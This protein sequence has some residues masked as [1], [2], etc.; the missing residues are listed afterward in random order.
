M[1]AADIERK[2]RSGERL[3]REDGIDLYGCD[4]LAWLGGLAHEVRSRHS[5]DIAYFAAHLPQ[6]VTDLD[7]A[8]ALTPRWAADGVTELRL[9]TGTGTGAGSEA[10]A[11]GLAG[12]VRALRDALPEGVALTAY[13]LPYGG[14]DAPVDP[15]QL[16]GRVLRLRELQDEVGGFHVAVPLL[17]DGPRGATGAEVLK[18]FAVARLL[19]DNVEHLA[20]DW[21]LHTE[22]TAQ[23]ALQHGADE[24]TGRVVDDESAAGQDADALTREDLLV[25]I[26]DAGF[27]PVERDAHYGAVRSHEGPDPQRRETPQ[28][29]RV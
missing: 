15:A 3:T 16:V 26:R 7:Q 22:Q 4:D 17:Q 1:D 6:D 2:V 21:A 25:A 27:R 29:M 28:P 5:G 19:L 23:L 14:A 13:A 24:L 11:G 12:A 10:E 9:V 8:V 18:A 20:A